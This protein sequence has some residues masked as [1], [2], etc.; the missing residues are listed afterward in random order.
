M[1]VS[2]SQ[3]KPYGA[4]DLQMMAHETAPAQTLLNF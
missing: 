2:P 4:D 3:P 1:G